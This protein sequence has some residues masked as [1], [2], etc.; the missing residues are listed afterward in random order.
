[1]ICLRDCSI[2][3][4]VVWLEGKEK[5]SITANEMCHVFLVINCIIIRDLCIYCSFVADDHKYNIIIIK[6]WICS[7]NSIRIHLN[8]ACKSNSFEW[9]AW[10]SVCKIEFY[11]KMILTISK[12]PIHII[13]SVRPFLCGHICS[14]QMPK[15]DAFVS[16]DSNNLK[17]N[18]F[19]SLFLRCVALS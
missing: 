13:W 3:F 9:L 1:M 7:F 15:C 17:I 5:K 2:C 18:T 6:T 16:D 10:S 19:L 4:T 11:D 8:Y 12:F 14:G